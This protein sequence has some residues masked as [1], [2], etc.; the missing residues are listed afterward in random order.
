MTRTKH[1]PH[2][3]ALIRSRAFEAVGLP[4]DASG[5]AVHDDI[6]VTRA[7]EHRQGKAVAE[8]SARRLDA[9][10]ALRVSMAKSDFA[11][12]Y[13]A[14]RRLE[15]DI[16]ISLGQH[17]H[18]RPVDRVDCEQAAFCRVDAMIDASKRVM[19]IKARLA[20]REAYLLWELIAPTREY[21]TWRAAVAYVTGETNWNAQ[22]AA[23]RAACANLRDAYQRLD[24]VGKK[25]A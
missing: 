23:V 25:A 13:D 5:L 8:D 6:E 3:P 2:D 4:A 10:E 17:D 19:W 7:G 15:R 24:V 14:G 20:D 1:K 9:F 16:L 11:G 22:G 18:G 21:R 12:S